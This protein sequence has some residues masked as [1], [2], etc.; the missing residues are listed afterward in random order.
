MTRVSAILL[1]FVGLVVVPVAPAAAQPAAGRAW[2]AL[3]DSYSSGEGIDGTPA[4]PSDTLGQ[5]CRRATGVGTDATA[6]AAGAYQTVREELGFS[7]LDFVACTGNISDDATKQIQEAM[8]TGERG[9]W[10]IVS[11]SFG[12]NNIRFADIIMGCLKPRRKG[13]G[14]EYSCDVTEAQ[15]R[16]RVDM[17]VGTTP[18]D[19]NEYAGQVTLP[20][21]YDLVAQHVKPGGDV[22]VVGYPNL[23]EEP[24]RW[25]WLARKT[26]LCEGIRDDD[27][28]MLRAAGG[29]L[30]EQIGKAVAAADARYRDAGVRFH[31]V[32]IAKNPYELDGDQ[33]NR[34]SRCGGDPWLNGIQLDPHQPGTTW[35]YKK[36]SF[37]P[38]QTG[39]TNTARVIAEYVRNNVTFDDTGSAPTTTTGQPP[40]GGDG[41]AGAIARYETFLHAVGAEDIA[42]VCEI[43]GPAAKQAED[44]GFGPCEQT[45]PIT[46][47]MISA[48]QKA[49]LRTATI[50]PAAVEVRSPQE[51]EIPT[52]AIR[53]AGVFTESMLGSST[54]S[55]QDGDWFVV[56]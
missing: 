36:R 31:F 10:D 37:H 48:D 46:F 23:I 33:R 55:Y 26:G 44:E 3:G 47:A 41:V 43:A 54:M 52:A 25:T 29:Y 17:L 50:D 11:F 38:N 4:S 21:L 56:D 32:D 45:F 40:P 15:M 30:N 34:H 5:E 7:A 14:L 13:W 24:D 28:P 22:V 8:T 51:V 20:K 53:P 35:G 12:G 2:L 49:V 1:L 16:K 18:I 39:H 6:W 9:S 27:V 19:P 42:T